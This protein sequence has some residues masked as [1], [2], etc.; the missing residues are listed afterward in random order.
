MAC[1]LIEI[2]KIVSSKIIANLQV[3]YHADSI[4][5]SRVDCL[6]RSDDSNKILHELVGQINQIH[7]FDNVICKAE[8]S[9]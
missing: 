7:N 1:Y 6:S 4:K 3:S 5:F 2:F 8:E 9:S